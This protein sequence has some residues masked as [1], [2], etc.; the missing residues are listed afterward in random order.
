M[1]GRKKVMKACHNSKVKMNAESAGEIN[2]F[3]RTQFM[4]YYSNREE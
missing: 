1:D 3:E 4:R 2:P